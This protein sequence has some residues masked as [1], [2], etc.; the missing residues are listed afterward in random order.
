MHQ[1]GDKNKRFL[2][3]LDIWREANLNG[4]NQINDITSYA[5][6]EVGRVL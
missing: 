3:S 6:L 2:C 5:E 4:D 1:A